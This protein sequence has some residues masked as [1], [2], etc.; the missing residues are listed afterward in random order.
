MPTNILATGAA[1]LAARIK[2]SAAETVTYTRGSLTV[3]GGI[4]ATPGQTQFEQT[5]ADGFGVRI[6]ARDYI[7]TAADLVLAGNT[8]LPERGD[9][10]TDAASRVHEVLGIGNEPCWRWCDPSHVML[11]IHTKQIVRP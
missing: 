6:D 11:R 5:D 8:V 10:I 2:A 4:S 3:T 1:W 9:L 7:V